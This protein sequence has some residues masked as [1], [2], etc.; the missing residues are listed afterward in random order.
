MLKVEE[1]FIELPDE[2]RQFYIDRIKGNKWMP[3]SAKDRILKELEKEKVSKK[4]LDRL[5]KRMKG[6]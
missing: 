1:E 4:L 3:E 5:E 6:S 2:K